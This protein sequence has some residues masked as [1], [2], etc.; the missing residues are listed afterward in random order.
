MNNKSSNQKQKKIINTEARGND[1][2]YGYM[3]NVVKK[4]KKDL[5]KIEAEIEGLEKINN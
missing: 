3:A 1:K 4:A 5:E 2:I